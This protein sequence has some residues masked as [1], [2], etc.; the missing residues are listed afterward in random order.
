MR[1]FF[2]LIAILLLSLP[3]GMSISGC[4]TNV[5]AYCNGAGFGLKT[6][7]VF[8][9]DLE[10]SLTGISLAYGQTQQLQAATAKNCKGTAVSVGKF[11]YGTTN[12]NVADISPTN[13]LCAGTWNRTSAGGIADFTI[14]NPPS[15]PA[16]AIVTAQ[17]GGATSNPVVVYVHPQVTSATL[18][19]PQA[20]DGSPVC[21]SQNATSQ[22]NATAFVVGSSSPFCAP[23]TTGVPDCSVNLGHFTY[24]AQTPSI[25]TI[26]QNGVATAHQPGT[27][28]ISAT[29]S[30]VSANAGYF[31]TCP[32][33]S[34]TL[35]QPAGAQGTT[36]TQSNPQPLTATIIDTLGNTITGLAL[37]YNSTNPQQIQVSG[38]GTVSTTFPG[39]AT[40]TAICQPPT[41]NPSPVNKIGLLGT[42]LPVTANTLPFQS[43]GL[44]NSFLWLASSQSMFFTPIDLSTGTVA[45][46]I[47]L[48]YLPN[49]MV[50][51]QAGSSL[52]FGSYR[53]L[54]IFNATSNQLTKEDISVPGVVLAVSPDGTTAVICDQIRQVIYLYT[55][56]TGTASSVGG[57]GTRAKYSPDG[58]T[59]YVVGPNNLY[60]HNAATGWSTYSSIPTT[61]TTAL[62]TCVSANPNN[63]PGNA[64]TFSPFC[65]PDAAVTV[66][67]VGTF[68]SGSPTTARSFC[69]NNASN[70]PYF[71][72]AGSFATETD[73]L[74]ATADGK[75]ILGATPTQLTDF[76]ITA[77][78]GPCPLPT[79][80]PFTFTATP[81]TTALPVAPTA[82]DQVVAS[83]D[84][85]VAFVTYSGTTAAGAVLPAYK[86]AAPGAVSSVPLTGGATAPVAGV[87]SRDAEFFFVGTAGDNLI[88]IIDIPT[89]TDS[90]QFDPKLT[91]PNGNAVPVQFLATKPRSTT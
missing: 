91:D 65:S 86:P 40:V 17:G 47:K 89:L 78:S 25:V 39:T 60:V 26:D 12:M 62:P 41:C 56:S 71:P 2:T 61:T 51:D 46:P 82:I 4:A 69:D 16:T 80:A 30:G 58:K 68:L 75:H 11:T 21:V 22:L 77:P 20:A 44:D 90:K 70:P 45:A 34:I 10:P 83:P 73:Q 88:H 49:S 29:I 36:I 50:L 31:S 37:D 1:R 42:G 67:S 76:A 43:T 87:F 66:P 32:P 14:C 6:T 53:E 3:V 27:T 59:L 13:V 48:P 72:Q 52:Y 63:L 38:T 15:A 7:D 81:T 9:I 28:V 19:G 8:S 24:A 64:N 33:A 85:S 79:A 18:L 54:M 74:T 84:S 57:L 55:I 23:N 35:S 5:A